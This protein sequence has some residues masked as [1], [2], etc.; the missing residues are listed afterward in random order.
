MACCLMAPSHHLKH[1]LFL[2][3]GSLGMIIN[4]GVNSIK[5]DFFSRK[6]IWKCH[7]KNVSH[8]VQAWLCCQGQCVNQSRTSYRWDI[9]VYRIKTVFLKSTTMFDAVLVCFRGTLY[10]WYLVVN[11]LWPSDTIWQHRYMSTLAQVMACC[12]KAP[13]HY[14]NQC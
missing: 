10:S 14:T 3:V 8:F 11:S 12:L 4:Y 1:C 5:A 13:S 9:Y 7:L 6:F 2:S